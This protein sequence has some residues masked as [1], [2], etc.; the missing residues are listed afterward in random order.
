MVVASHVTLGG[1]IRE[2]VDEDPDPSPDVNNIKYSYQVSHAHAAVKTK[3]LL[4]HWRLLQPYVSGSL[5]LAFN[6][7]SN[8]ISTST[9][10][11]ESINPGFQ[12]QD[13]T[14]LTYTVGVGVQTT[15]T[16]HWHV[17]VGYEFADWGKSSL[18]RA[19]WQTESSGLSLSHLYT[20]ALL[21]GVTYTA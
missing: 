10:P 12:P 6:R 15:W 19:P 13:S 1:D 14:A 20:N 2:D 11:E 21:F 16:D 5:G 3:L 7:A 17:H 4:N 9:F 8:F 18:A